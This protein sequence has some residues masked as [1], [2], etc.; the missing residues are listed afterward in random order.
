MISELILEKGDSK[1]VSL[2]IIF[3]PPILRL[4][5]CNLHWWACINRFRWFFLTIAI[6]DKT[7]LKD[8]QSVNFSLTKIISKL[9]CKEVYTNMI[10]KNYINWN[11]YLKALIISR[12]EFLI[13][14]HLWIGNP[15]QNYVPYQL[16]TEI[17][18]LQLFYLFND[19]PNN[20]QSSQHLNTIAMK[21][22]KAMISHVYK[23]THLDDFNFSRSPFW[24]PVHAWK[25]Q[26]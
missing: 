5:D 6:Q 12:V 10:R 11:Y 4:L 17:Q 2:Q 20:F 13:C 1:Y 3:L 18:P 19:K 26:L 21:I 15:N 9:C 7:I 14:C 23:L 8:D 24:Y 25:I 16:E 22:Y